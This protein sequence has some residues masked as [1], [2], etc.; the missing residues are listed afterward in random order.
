M[1]VNIKNES[2]QK[3]FYN[4]R[5]PD[6]KKMLVHSVITSFLF[7]M[8]IFNGSISVRA[9]EE[10]KFEY[11][12]DG[13]IITGEYVLDTILYPIPKVNKPGKLKP[14]I[15]PVFNIKI[16]R[17][18]DKEI[19]GYNKK[20]L[21]MKN[22][23]AT[24]DPENCDGSYVVLTYAEYYWCIYETKNWTI[25]RH[26]NK[27]DGG[28]IEPG[29]IECRWDQKDPNVLFY[30]QGSTL[31]RYKVNQDISEVVYD[32]AKDIAV[33][34]GIKVRIQTRTEGTP[35]YD[36]RY[37][38]FM[39]EKSDPCMLSYDLDNKRIIGM[40]KGSAGDSISMSPSGK[41]IFISQNT[42]RMKT[43]FTGRLDICPYHKK[44]HGDL[45]FDTEGNEV[46]VH[47]CSDDWITMHDLKTGKST[48]LISMIHDSTWRDYTW[49]T[50]DDKR[51]MKGF[52][53]SGNC[54]A[55]PGW[56][57]IATTG[58]GGRETR[59]WQAKSLYMLELK[60]NPRIW[61]I[62]HTHC[63]SSNYLE[64]VFAT[65]NTKGTKIYFGSNWEETG[66]MIET[67]IAELPP[68]WYEDFMGKEKAY[69][70]RAKVA[71]ILGITV[72]RFVH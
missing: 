33:E 43:D 52:H 22:E 3:G 13:K 35:S 30:R 17:V 46:F 56:V 58:E 1:T 57:L 71:N 68:N 66:G 61:R 24:A 44:N 28:E 67:Y 26:L 72:K 23:Y 45:A 12:I 34:E 49:R 8:P 25:Y 31:Y 63:V 70:I 39:T 65:I 2:G 53:I 14:F 10:K 47:Q 50:S 41:W 6:L 51:P 5:M 60:E 36:S 37:W 15:D 55:T 19:D 69:R 59:N 32:F 11:L 29:P 62:A 7:F 20:W 16:T 40:K 54:Y 18:T 64:S 38:A 27:Y 4:K 21:S 42:A 9:A 48:R